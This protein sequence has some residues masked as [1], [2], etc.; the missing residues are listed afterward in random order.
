[1]ADEFDRIRAP[2]YGPGGPSCYCCQP[3]F[4]PKEMRRYARRKMKQDLKKELQEE[5]E[6]KE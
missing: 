1:M 5:T 2:K 3:G 6:T 4:T